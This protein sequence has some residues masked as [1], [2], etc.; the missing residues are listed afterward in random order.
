[1][2][3]IAA[4]GIE[5]ILLL[6][7]ESYEAT[8]LEY[9]KNAATIAKEYFSCVLLEVHP[10]ET[11]EYQELF[12]IGADGVTIYQ[13]TYDRNRYKE[14]HLAGKKSDYDF[15]LG[16]PERAAKAGM[17]Y[18]SLGILLGLSDAASDLFELFNHLNYLEKNFPGIEYNLSFPRLRN[19]KGR[20]FA[21][22]DVDDETFV[23]IIS[24]ARINFPRVGI[25]LSTREKPSLRDHLLGIGITRIS[26]GSNTSVGGYEISKDSAQDPQF[27][28]EDKRSVQEIIKS[29]KNNNFDPVFTSWRTIK[30]TI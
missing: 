21:K 22:C 1:M 16:T 5:D 24:L 10:M 11:N 13:E 6:T 3:A 4:T 30:N 28:I 9:L 23:K 2:K 15:R 29:L 8:S 14:V 18:I 25:T 26:A 17:R 27:D 20:E 12:S 7:G 19:I